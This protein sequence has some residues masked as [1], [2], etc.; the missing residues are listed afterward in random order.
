MS[1]RR[2]P[3]LTMLFGFLE[4]VVRRVRDGEEKVWVDCVQIDIQGFDTA[5]DWKTTTLE[6]E[7]WV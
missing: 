2:L 4:G 7:V 1:R 5:G 6:T 3:K